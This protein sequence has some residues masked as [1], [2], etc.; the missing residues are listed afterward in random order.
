VREL[1]DDDGTP[2]APLLLGA[3]VQGGAGVGPVFVALELSVARSLWDGAVEPAFLD[4][5]E[6]FPRM[7]L[8]SVLEVWTHV[9]LFARMM[10]Q[11]GLPERRT[12]WTAGIAGSMAVIDD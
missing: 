3:G 2:R 1:P 6:Q 4:V 10:V 5:A 9:Q 7:G 11:D 8:L 12:L